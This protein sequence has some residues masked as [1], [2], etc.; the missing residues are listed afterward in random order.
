MPKRVKYE[1]EKNRKRTGREQGSSTDSKNIVWVFDKID[2]SGKFAFDLNRQDF[3][4]KEIL[5]KQIEYNG[6]TWIEAKQQ[7]HDRT[8]KSKHH[9]LAE[10]TLSKEAADRLKAR[11]LENYSDSIFSFALQNKLRVVGYRENEFFHVLWY[12]P[13][14]EICPSTK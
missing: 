1:K 4:H 2:L 5:G 8:G 9:Y 6:M 13:G 7:T 12:D 14:H 10:G 11:H 3:K